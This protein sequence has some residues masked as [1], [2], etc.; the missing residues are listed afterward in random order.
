MGLVG[1]CSW[2]LDAVVGGF[3][4]WFDEVSSWL[5]TFAWKERSLMVI[6]I[7]NERYFICT[8][9]RKDDVDDSKKH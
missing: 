6:V 1:S 8:W 2:L 7:V 5:R 9:S 4:V 3:L